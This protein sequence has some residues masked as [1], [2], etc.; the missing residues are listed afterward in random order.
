MK[1][2]STRQR[3]TAS[4]LLV[5]LISVGILMALGATSFTVINN[6]YRV[7]HQAASWQEA[8][9]SADA[10]IEVGV[11]EIRKRLKK[12]GDPFRS[13]TSNGEWTNSEPYVDPSE[14]DVTKYRV[15]E[16]TRAVILRDSGGSVLDLTGGVVYSAEG[17]LK[18]T[19]DVTIDEPPGLID[20]RTGEQWYRVV[21]TGVCGL[22]GG[23]GFVAGEKAD[24]R[25]RK[26]DFLFDH[27]TRAAI[28]ATDGPRATRRIEAIV[29]PQTAG[30]DPLFGV[31]SIDLNNL[32]IVVDSFDSADG[33]YDP[34][35]PRWNGNISTNGPLINAGNAQIYGTASTHGGD[36]INN[37]N[38]RG[39]DPNFQPSYLDNPD[40]I[41]DDFYRDVVPISEP[42]DTVSLPAGDAIGGSTTI[43]ASAGDPTQVKVSGID[44]KGKEVLRI[45]GA[46]DSNGDLI[47]PAPAT[48]AQIVITGNIAMAGQAQIVLDPGVYVRIFV[49]GDTNIAGQGVANPNSPLN[50]QL[51]GLDRPPLSDGTPNIGTIKIAG[52]GGFRGVVY[53]PNYDIEMKG[54]GNADTIFGAFTGYT[55][56]MTGVQS[57]HYDEQLAKGSLITGYNIV[58]WFEDER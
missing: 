25:L 3:T 43:N 13:V 16:R 38:V 26:F 58:S 49:G 18:S 44:L 9:L 23:R 53:A 7:V 36:V 41:R 27:F 6:K 34:L 19:V 45:R 15:H 50:F 55:I 31:K 28:P 35:N 57:V 11:A 51:Y 2:P 54:G 24:G 14:P 10:G 47:S 20:S 37:A 21:A 48:Y 1:T 56:R 32:N 12:N 52:N 33:P 4:A 29:A 42:D 22:P 17:K 39:N 8:L 46:V 5:A 40:R 30:R